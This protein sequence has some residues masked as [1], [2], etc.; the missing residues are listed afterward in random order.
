MRT[1]TSTWILAVLACLASA[2]DDI[3]ISGTLV[4]ESGAPIADATVALSGLATTTTTG[5]DGTFSLVGS[6]SDMTGVLVAGTSGT[7]QVAIRGNL[8]RLVGATG[9]GWSLDLLGADGRILASRV[10]FVSG[11]AV[12]PRTGSRVRYARLRASD[13]IVANWTRSAGGAF[14]RASVGYELVFSKADYAPE[15]LALSSASQ[16]GILDTLIASTPW[17]PSGSLTKS[18][19]QVRILAAGKTFAMGSKLQ[20]LTLTGDPYTSEGY[21]HSAS[22]TKDFWMDTTEV[23]QSAW[24]TSMM[25]HYGSAS[26]SGLDATY[27]LGPTF[28]V[29][30]VYDE[31]WGAGG[32]ILFANARSAAEGLDTM[33]SYT[34]RTSTNANAILTGV[35]LRTGVASPG[36]RLPTEAEW[37]Y[38]ARGGTTTDAYW[39]DYVATP[40]SSDTATISA[41]AVWEANAYTFGAGQPGF[42]THEVATGAPNAYGLYDML[43]NVSEWTEDQWSSSYSAGHATDPVHGGET[44]TWRAIRGGNWTNNP[45][46]LRAANRQFSYNGYFPEKCTGFRLVRTAQ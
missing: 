21:R 8:A 14:R 1:R 25:A 5:A 40:G 39:G 24:S 12:L 23:T 26:D 29:Y 9:D 22:F 15:K 34:S 46:D 20:L 10:P 31:N 37:E 2:A 45:Q 17:I 13:N 11:T 19:N 38:A 4:G 44:E 36:Y 30:G 16:T 28:P 3:S 42:G 18:G 32:A 33:Y 35:A 43:G 6:T 41:H 7:P 27:G